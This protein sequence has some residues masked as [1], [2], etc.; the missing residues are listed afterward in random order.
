M[1]ATSVPI[2]LRQV[3]RA[4]LHV[5]NSCKAH[6]HLS[7]PQAMHHAGDE[8]LLGQ[9]F[10]IMKA[11]TKGIKH[12]ARHNSR[13]L[14]YKHS[15]IKVLEVTE[16]C[17]RVVTYVVVHV[18]KC[19]ED[20]GSIFGVLTTVKPYWLRANNCIHGAIKILLHARNN[21]LDAIREEVSPISGD[22]VA[23]NVRKENL[24]SQKDRKANNTY[25]VG[26]P[27][28]VFEQ[29]SLVRRREGIDN[30]EWIRE[31]PMI[32]ATGWQGSGGIIGFFIR[33]GNH[34]HLSNNVD[35]LTLSKRKSWGEKHVFRWRYE[36]TVKIRQ[37]H[38]TQRPELFKSRLLDTIL[39]RGAK[40]QDFRHVDQISRGV[41]WNLPIM[42]E[43]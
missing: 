5:P 32:V 18:A 26:Q 17:S 13:P 37:R 19:N 24:A 25:R 8:F 2:P 16:C 43:A 41:V 4:G 30:R 11:F 14:R 34:I 33:Q 21:N 28:I 31:Q 20:F 36:G 10:Q 39:V 35:I 42:I 40:A 9:A 1:I 3:R 15:H 23:A 27:R 22:D 12:P 7:G 38:Q 29:Q 6:F